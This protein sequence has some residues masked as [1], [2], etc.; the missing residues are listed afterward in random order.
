[1][2]QD[3]EK[4]NKTMHK[5]VRVLDKYEDSLESGEGTLDKTLKHL[6]G[7]YTQVCILKGICLRWSN[8]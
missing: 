1:M 7:G 8:F 2:K 3:N 5:F 4:F 6:L